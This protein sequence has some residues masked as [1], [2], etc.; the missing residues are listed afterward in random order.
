LSKQETVDRFCERDDVT[1]AAGRG[2]PD[3]ALEA[4][5]EEASFDYADLLC[6]SL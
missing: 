1:H 3:D 6:D 5:F 4:R 2:S